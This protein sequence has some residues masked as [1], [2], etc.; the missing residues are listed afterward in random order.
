MQNVYIAKI[1][2]PLGSITAIVDD[3]TYLGGDGTDTPV[4]IEVDGAGNPYVAGTTTSS[5]FPTTETNAYQS[6]PEVSGTHVFV[7]K[8]LSR[9][10]SA[11]CSIRRIFPAIALTPPAGG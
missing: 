2:P 5:N 1:T 7:T 9:T 4:G 11:S 3:V 8:M 6:S 10:T